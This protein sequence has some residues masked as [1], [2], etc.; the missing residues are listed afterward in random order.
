[1][2]TNKSALGCVIIVSNDVIKMN[3]NRHTGNT[4]PIIAK[5]MS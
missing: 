3:A 5:Y 1:M 2:F 4:L